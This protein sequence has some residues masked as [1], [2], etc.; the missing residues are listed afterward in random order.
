[1]PK[2]CKQSR[3]GVRTEVIRD[4]FIVLQDA[5]NFCGKFVVDESGVSHWEPSYHNAIARG[6][7]GGGRGVV[8]GADLVI[9]SGGGF[10]G[11]R[12]GGW[13]FSP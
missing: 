6:W 11:E 9:L 5:F 1:M 8:G 10:L 12:K 2:N 7:E 4:F 13:R 3:R